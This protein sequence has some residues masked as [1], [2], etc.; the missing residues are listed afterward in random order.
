MKNMQQFM[1]QAQE[2]QKR[3]ED[4]QTKLAVTEFTGQAGGG[5]VKITINGKSEMLKV[6]IDPSLLAADEKEV[7]EDLL[8]AA[9]NDA[10]RQAEGSFSSEMAAVT[11]GVL[12]PGMKLPF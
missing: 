5:M 3:I 2:I 9:F 6:S 11:G 1:R 4:I 10:K 7:L 8:I 12:P